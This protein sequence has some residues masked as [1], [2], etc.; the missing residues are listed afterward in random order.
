MHARA[1]GRTGH[2]PTFGIRPFNIYGP[3]QLASSPYSGVISVFAD[4]LKRRENLTIY[5]NGSQTRDFIH[6]TD[7]VNILVA[8]LDNVSVDAPVINVATG[9]ETS[10]LDVAHSLGAILGHEAEI[11]FAPARMGDIRRSVAD[12]AG[13]KSIFGITPRIHVAEGLRFLLETQPIP[14]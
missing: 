1:A 10:I 4:R 12:I 13:M 7:V 5:G 8:A 6:V 3:R 11:N 2:V 9:Q 14:D